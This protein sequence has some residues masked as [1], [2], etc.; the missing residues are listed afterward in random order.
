MRSLDDLRLS[1]APAKGGGVIDVGLVKSAVDRASGGFTALMS[2]LS[3][4]FP[5]PGEELERFVARFAHECLAA[6]ID[7]SA[8]ANTLVITGALIRTTHDGR[9][10]T[11]ASLR[12]V[13]NGISSDGA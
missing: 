13:A 6:G 11:V 4:Q 5:T 10:S 2:N 9:D 8:L 1:L 3:H 7:P 12:A